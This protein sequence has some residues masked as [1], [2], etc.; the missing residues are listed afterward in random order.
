MDRIQQRGRA[1]LAT[2]VLLL[3]AATAFADEARITV[4]KFR[5]IGNSLLT[6]AEVRT[7]LD[8][9]AG[10]A[11][12]L[13]EIKLAARKLRALYRTRGY[14]MA[15]AYVPP[16]EFLEDTVEIRVQEGRYGKVKAEGNKHYKDAF[17]ARFFNP[18]RRSGILEQTSL[19]RALLVLNQ[20]LDLRVQ[21]VLE[22]RK[23]GTVDVTL[24]VKDEKPVHAIVDYDNF[25]VRLVGR[26]R[27]GAGVIAGNALFQGDVLAL[28][29]T[30][31]FN[32][33]KADPFYFVNYGVPVGDR[34][35]RIEAS[36]AKANT[37]V[38]S[39]LAALGIQGAANIYTVR[40]TILDDVTLDSSTAWFTEL[41]LKDIKN[42]ALDG[43]LQ[44]SDDQVRTMAFGH[45]GTVYRDTGKT[46]IA[47][48]VQ[49]VVGLG[50]ALGGSE[51]TDATSR[52]GADNEFVR[53]TVEVV[54]IHRVSDKGFVLGRFVGQLSTDGL[55][56]PEQFA[57]GGPD[58]VRGY[59]QGEFLGDDGYAASAEYR[60]TLWQERLSSVQGLAFIDHGAAHL[61]KPLGIEVE[62]QDLTGAGIGMRGQFGRTVSARADLG[63]ALDP[64]RNLDGDRT[65]LHAQVACRF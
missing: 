54:A 3:W 38:G 32:V 10:K 22:A 61:Q 13:R 57:L 25:G 6:P 20:N 23:D 52:L 33:E 8:S 31:P 41:A 18:A 30:H 46:Q 64:K 51:Q 36:F 62:T 34:G 12:T 27:A 37:F 56:V 16:Q 59:Q 49:A 65:K 11:L 43:A 28:K 24:K 19:Q 9:Y 63:W 39:E 47:H 21:S 55:M 40:G 1:V 48:V 14:V 17:I 58:T 60:H 35:N 29:V 44:V 7:T 15:H 50:K 4:K 2:L 53:G 5:V 42:T 26:N 45:R